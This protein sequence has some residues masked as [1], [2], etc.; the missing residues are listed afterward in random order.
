MDVDLVAHGYM[1]LT[2]VQEDALVEVVEERSE[3]LSPTRPEELAVMAYEW[4]MEDPAPWFDAKHPHPWAARDGPGHKWA[5]RFVE[6]H[7]DR[8]G[9]RQAEIFSAERANA[10]S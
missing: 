2:E 7:S 6:R 10:S 8:I 1:V 9:W 3:M 5:E 4:A